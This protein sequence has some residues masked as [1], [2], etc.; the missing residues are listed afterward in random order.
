[1]RQVE[2]DLQ[3][4]WEREP[5]VLLEKKDTAELYGENETGN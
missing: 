1:M 5:S 3:R 2:A 4:A